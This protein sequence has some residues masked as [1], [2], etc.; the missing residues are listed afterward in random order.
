MSGFLGKTA[1]LEAGAP[2]VPAGAPAVPAAVVGVAGGVSGTILAVRLL[3][4]AQTLQLQT[5]QP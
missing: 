2:A 5:R 4:L 3:G 1:L